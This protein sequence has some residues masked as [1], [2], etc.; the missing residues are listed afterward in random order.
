MQQKADVFEQVEGPRGGGALVHFLLVLGLMRVDAFKDAESPE[1]HKNHLSVTQQLSGCVLPAGCP[2]L[3]LNSK[4]YYVIRIGCYDV[5][6]KQVIS[7][8]KFIANNF[9][10][11]LHV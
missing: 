8:I 9:D 7:H 11:L 5:V 2:D 4:Q 6:L 1:K 10:N 3:K